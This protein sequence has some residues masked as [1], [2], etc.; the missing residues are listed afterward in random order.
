MSSLSGEAWPPRRALKQKRG[1]GA[2]LGGAKVGPGRGSFFVLRRAGGRARARAPR[3]SQPE[4]QR[5]PERTTN[6]TNGTATKTASPPLTARHR[7]PCR[8][9]M[10]SYPLKSAMFDRSRTVRAAPGT[11]RTSPAGHWDST[12][13]SGY[14]DRKYQD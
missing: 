10:R 6:E 8:P 1:R 12:T 13:K 3:E 2:G 11:F 4:R 14:Q 9:A 7:S 5:G